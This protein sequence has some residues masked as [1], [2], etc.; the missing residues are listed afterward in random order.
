[1]GQLFDISVEDEIFLT[2][3]PSLDIQFKNTVKSTKS[4]TCFS[5]EIKQIK[6]G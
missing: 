6:Y 3:E 5:N 2:S 4:N 1:M